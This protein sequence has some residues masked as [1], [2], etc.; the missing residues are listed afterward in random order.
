MARM[1]LQKLGHSCLLVELDGARILIDPGV[2]TDAWH[3]VDN[4]D[5][6]LVTHQHPDHLDTEHLPALLEANPSAQIVC[7]EGSAAAFA[8]LGVEPTVANAGDVLDV[9]GQRVLVQGARHAVIHPDI[10]MVPNVGYVLGGLFHPGDQLTLPDPDAGVRVVAVPLSA[11]W[12][13][14]SETADFLRATGIAVAVPIHDVLLSVIGAA[15]YSRILGGL[16]PGT[17]LRPIDDERGPVTF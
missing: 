14:V 7:D 5:A 16:V 10:P 11:P 6:V 3:G 1:L 2:F 15:A 13:K 4:L 8:D 12:S 9:A 17:T